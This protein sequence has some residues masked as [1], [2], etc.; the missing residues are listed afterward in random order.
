M[1]ELQ[2]LFPQEITDD[3]FT[4]SSINEPDLTMG[5]AV[6]VSG[7]NS[8]TGTRVIR[9]ETHRIYERITAGVS[10]TPPEDDAVIWADAGPTNKW[11]WADGY[12]DTTT[13]SSAPI[14]IK[15]MPGTV[16]AMTVHGAV[17]DSIQITERDAVGT[18][19][20]DEAYSLFEISGEDPYWEYFFSFPV[21]LD[22]LT[23]SGL[24]PEPA[25]EI[26]VTL[27]ITGSAFELGR[28]SMGNFEPLGLPEY[29]IK[30]KPRA[31]RQ[32]SRK[33]GEIS[34]VPG[35]TYVDLEGS[36]V[37]DADKANAAFKVIKR[38]LNIPVAVVPSTVQ[39]Y[40]YL[41]N[42]GFLEADIEASGP[43][44]ARISFSMQGIV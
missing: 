3:S 26:T 5:E 7:D 20:F 34:F 23:I 6:W 4:F 40:N 28:V 14:V 39:Q 37:L 11:A 19:L 25:C 10:T 43:G 18:V 22:N 42:Y 29:G 1:S 16:T 35:R 13:K 38:L 9:V 21:T 27:G 44:H 31:D 33:F 41:N 30:A 24:Y 2:V 12:R 8:A 36:S 32:L 15:A 17:A